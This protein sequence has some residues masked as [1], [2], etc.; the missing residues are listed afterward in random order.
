MEIIFADGTTEKVTVKET[1]VNT[2]IFTA[3]YKIPKV[4]AKSLQVNY[5]YWGFNKSVELK[6]N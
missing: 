1:G 2:G 4:K 5:G 6:L 3:F